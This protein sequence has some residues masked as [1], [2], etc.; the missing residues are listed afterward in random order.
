LLFWVGSLLVLPLHQP[1]NILL[2]QVEAG[3]EATG[4]LAVEQEDTEPLRL[5]LCLPALQL[6]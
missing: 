4:A 3:V 1:L 6:P 5:L 2:L